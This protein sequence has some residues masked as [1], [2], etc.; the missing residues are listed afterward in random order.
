MRCGGA[1]RLPVRCSKEIFKQIAQN[2][3]KFRNTARYCLGNLADFDPNNLV[4]ADQLEELDKWVLTKLDELV[5][6]CRKAYNN[7]EFHVV[8]HAINDFCV[9]ELSS[10][11]LDIIKDRLYCE[12]ANGN[13]R[14]SA[15]TALYLIVDAMAK[16]FAPILAFTCD[17]IWQSMP[18]RESDDSRN[19]LLNQMP[20]SFDAYVLDK[21]TMDKWATVMKLRQDVN[22][23]LEVARADK[24][25]GKALEAHVSLHSDDNALMQT[26]KDVNLAE[27][28]I[29]SSCAWEAAPE[30]ATT[31]N[32][33]NL[34]GLTVGVVEARGE[35]CPRCWMHSEEA[36]ENGLCKRCAAVIS[37]MDLE[38]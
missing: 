7:Y 1:G 25:I 12:E 32:G 26:C 13:R 21:A 2:Y 17:E 30:G 24:R 16:L 34:P 27:I 20:E 9:V 3:L 38:I 28:F 33:A 15:Q 23:V 5:K 31:G 37:Q 11:Y 19:V 10:F 22:G 18:H 35:K 14:R 36:D 29:V 4:S 6:F 8:S